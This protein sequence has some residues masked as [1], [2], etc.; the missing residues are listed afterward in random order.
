MRKFW[1][2]LVFTLAALTV[3]MQPVFAKKVALIIGNGAYQTIPEL[4]NPANDA[5]LAS[6][7]FSALGFETETLV[8]A[9]AQ[10]MLTALEGFQTLSADADVAVIFFAGHGVQADNVNY[11]LPTDTDAAS[12]EAFETSSVTM[13]AFLEA[14]HASSNVRLL[15]VD[16]CRDNPFAQTR[17]IGNVIGA[18]ERGLA[19]VNHQL[20]DLVV[21]YSAQP[22][23]TALDGTGSN[24]PFME[25][26]SNVL[27]AQAQV[28][29][30]DALIDITNFVR[31]ETASRQLPYIEGTLSVHLELAL[32]SAATVSGAETEAAC[33]G[34]TETVSLSPGGYQSL[35]LGP[36]TRQLVIDDAGTAAVTLCL[37]DGKLQ[38]DGRYDQAFTADDAGNREN[39]GAGYYFETASGD[40]A[41]L[42]IYTDPD[43]PGAKLEVGVYLDG[44]EISWVETGWAF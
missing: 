31:T 16:A 41:H 44:T 12:R 19:R 33:S 32:Q 30:S 38:A 11:L 5:E 8:D 37:A 22:N 15:I 1:P 23:Q 28:K 3:S 7:T 18:G 29:L 34:Q 36:Q 40:E 39:G 26:L 6:A 10:D 27:T 35:T 42:W 14:F 2:C 24:S 13:D 9:S 20:D 25:A 17:S 21:V 43:T 4:R